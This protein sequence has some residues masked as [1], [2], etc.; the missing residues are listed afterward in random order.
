MIQ[1][2]FFSTP[3]VTAPTVHDTAVTTPVISSHV[4]TINENEEPVVQDTI[5]TVVAQEEELQQP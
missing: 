3:A 4:A 1:K 2:P 5:K